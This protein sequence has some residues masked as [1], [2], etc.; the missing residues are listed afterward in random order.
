MNR[1]S[2]NDTTTG[3]FSVYLVY[4]LT[5]SLSHSYVMS[6]SIDIHFIIV[7]V[8]LL[9]V[10]SLYGF[11]TAQQCNMA[12]SAWMYLIKTKI[13]T[14]RQQVYDCTICVNEYIN[15]VLKWITERNVY[16]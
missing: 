7:T 10:I 5:S 13:N 2:C 4:K 1:D 11:F 12:I 16:S 9:G 15:S 14:I 6:A 3:D 8:E